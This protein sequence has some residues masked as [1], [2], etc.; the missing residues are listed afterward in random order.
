MCIFVVV[1]DCVSVFDFVFE[2]GIIDKGVLFM[3]FSCWWFMQFVDFL[4]YVVEGELFDVV[5]DCVMFVQLLE[6]LLIECVV[7]GYIIGFGWV[8][9]QESGMVCGI[10]LFIGLNNGDWLFEFL[11]ILVYKVLMGEYDENIMF[12]CVVEF[13]GVECVVELCDVFFVIYVKVVVIVEEK[14]LIFVD[15]KFEFGMDVDGI[16][17]LVDEVFMSDLFCYWDVEVWCIGMIFGE[18]MV[19]FDKQIVCDWFV[20][21]WDKQGELLL[22][23]DDVV[24]CIVDCYCELIECFGV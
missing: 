2:F 16:L 24:E 19:S 5:V 7:C 4:N 15:I 14:G 3:W 1:F 6:M 22:F 18:W 8:E 21:N 17:C 11:F 12:D 13:V 9:Y 23:L 10:L 20:V